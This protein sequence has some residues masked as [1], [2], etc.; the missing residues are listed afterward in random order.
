[1][2]NA[3][4]V[5]NTST[6]KYTV[7][8]F[9]EDDYTKLAKIAFTN[10]LRVSESQQ[11]TESARQLF[12]AAQ[13]NDLISLKSIAEN[14][15]MRLWEVPLRISQPNS[16][17]NEME[18]GLD[19]NNPVEFLEYLKSKFMDF[20]ELE[21]SKDWLELVG[22]IF[23]NV[24]LRDGSN[25]LHVAAFSGSVDC[26][27]FILEKMYVDIN[28]GN[29]NME[30][31]LHYA[32]RSTNISNFETGEV[33][34]LAAQMCTLLLDH[35]ADVNAR[36]RLNMIPLDIARGCNNKEVCKVLISNGSNI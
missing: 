20:A 25:V 14:C 16:N 4:P 35:G 17:R 9:H 18:H 21:D 36:N 22:R 11:Y 30:T 29:A 27:K 3:P 2:K 12:R 34:T 28:S 26:A 13:N 31:P 24:T 10:V 8:G 32:A 33:V 23:T 15:N 19:R 6:K 7:S 1:M 5:N